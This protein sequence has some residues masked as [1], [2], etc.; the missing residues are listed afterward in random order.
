MREERVR[1]PLGWI[2]VRF[3]PGK[4]EPLRFRW[5]G[6]EFAV[7]GRNAAWTDRTTHPVRH[8][9]SVN[10]ESGETFQLCF[11]EGDSVWI[12]DSLMIP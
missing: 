12:L 11:V 4:I 1:E 3:Q 9:F 8:F 6:R 7:T 2:L 10:V 5:A